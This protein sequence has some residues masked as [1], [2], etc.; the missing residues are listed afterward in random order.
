MKRLFRIVQQYSN[1]LSL[2][3]P[4]EIVKKFKIS[5]GDV[6]AVSIQDNKIVVEPLE[7]A[8]VTSDSTA[9]QSHVGCGQP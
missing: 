6:L 7:L 2:G 8:K 5:K 3:I 1:S 4:N 9:N